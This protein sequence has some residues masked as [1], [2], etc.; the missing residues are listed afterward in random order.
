VQCDDWNAFNRINCGFQRAYR[1]GR[2]PTLAKPFVLTGEHYRMVK[3]RYGIMPH[4]IVRWQNENW[5]PYE[6]LRVPTNAHVFWAGFSYVQLLSETFL[7]LPVSIAISPRPCTCTRALIRSRNGS[8][9]SYNQEKN[10]LDELADQKAVGNFMQAHHPMI[11]HYENTF[12]AAGA[13]WNTT[14]PSL[15]RGSL[16]PLSGIGEWVD[17]APMGQGICGVGDSGI[18]ANNVA[19][20]QQYQASVVAGNPTAHMNLYQGRTA[21]DV[22]RGNFA[23]P[24]SPGSV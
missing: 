23:M 18:A 4:H 8:T 14:Q 2:D 13:Q 22:R 19:H 9:H 21:A 12:M 24:G 1:E 3:G 7:S 15:A 20:F 11:T 16:E 5:T 6:P 10:S 17:L